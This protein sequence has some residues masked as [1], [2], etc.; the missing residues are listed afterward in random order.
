M[1]TIASFAEEWLGRAG[2]VFAILFVSYLTLNWFAPQ[3]L[4]SP[5]LLIAAAA[6]GLWLLVR[7]TRRVLRAAVWRLRNRLLVTYVFIAV[8]PIVLIL[9]L[10]TLGAYSLVNQLAVYLV[11]SELERRI[12]A[13]EDAAHSIVEFSPERM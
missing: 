11:T 6:A 7:V 5:A 1:R 8:V 9:S 3:T 13:L 2:I 10:A 12:E 4:A